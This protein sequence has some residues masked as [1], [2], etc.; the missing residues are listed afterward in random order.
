MLNNFEWLGEDIFKS[1]LLKVYVVVDGVTKS[2]NYDYGN[3]F[4]PDMNELKVR[5]GNVDEITK[6]LTMSVVRFYPS[7]CERGV[8][9]IDIY[10]HKMFDIYDRATDM[11]KGK[12]GENI[13]FDNQMIAFSLM[14]GKWIAS[15]I[16]DKPTEELRMVLELSKRITYNDLG[17]YD[18]HQLLMTVN[19]INYRRKIKNKLNERC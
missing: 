9:Y 4:S 14:K 1:L 6:L 5:D 19:D 3:I 10:L 12:G 7:I 15:F 13:P 18:R 16:V 17:L 11:I 2:I 8:S